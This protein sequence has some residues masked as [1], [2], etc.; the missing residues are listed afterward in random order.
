[1]KTRI[2][3]AAVALLGLA[4]C[5]QPLPDRALVT[6]LRVL[7]VRAEPPEA[8]PG[9]TVHFD[10]LV[11]DPKGNGR[12]LKRAWAICNPG[13]GGVGTCGNPANTA[14]LGSGLTADWTVPADA[15]SGLSATDAEMGRDVYVV[16]GVEFDDG[17]GQTDR[18]DHDVAFKRIRLSTNAD[19]N[20]NPKIDSLFVEKSPAATQPV[21]SGA[22][23]AIDA[24][25]SAD[26][27]QKW[28]SPNG[29]SGEEDARFTWLITAG[30]LD[31][32][33]TYADGPTVT[34]AWHTPGGS[35]DLTLWVVL[36]DGRGGIDWATRTVTRP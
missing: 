33:V 5:N 17:T 15:L 32:D 13:Q 11:A 31:S 25:P 10:A 23:L 21:A 18:S 27:R 3:V 28:S 19:P 14:V 8:A 22:T 36:R 12:V 34:N 35:G 20:R 7:G 9:T 1:M 29:T 4:G 16:L 6:T 26:S 30:S 24:A 2:L